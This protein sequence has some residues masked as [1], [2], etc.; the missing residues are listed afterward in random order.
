MLV[1][2]NSQCER[3][4]DRSCS[5]SPTAALPFS[6]KEKGWEQIQ[7]PISR[8]NLPKLS[9]VPA[10][11]VSERTTVIFYGCRVGWGSANFAK[12]LVSAAWRRR[13]G[14]YVRRLP[15]S[16]RTRLKVQSA[17]STMLHNTSCSALLVPGAPADS[18]P[19]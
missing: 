9:D 10:H 12:A 8:R 6:Y 2:S 17:S 1:V 14:R 19:P 5:P 16:L 3:L 18:S 7:T 15:R 11:G 13:K 4:R